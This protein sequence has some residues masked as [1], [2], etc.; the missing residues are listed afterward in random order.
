MGMRARFSLAAVVLVG[1]VG[2]THSD[3]E[4]ADAA[5]KAIRADRIEFHVDPLRGTDAAKGAERSPFRSLARAQRAS[6]E[7]LGKPGGDVVIV[8]RGGRHE[9]PEPL[10]FGPQDSGRAGRAVSARVPGRRRH[11]P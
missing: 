4:A 5:E 6:R 1:A 10:V 8:L 3:S 11:K 7:A 9:L 2:A